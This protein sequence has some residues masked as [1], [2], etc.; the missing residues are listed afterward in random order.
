MNLTAVEIFSA[1]ICLGAPQTLFRPS[2]SETSHSES[3][4]ENVRLNSYE[5]MADFKADYARFRVIDI[6][7]T[8]DSPHMIAA[9]DLNKDSTIDLIHTNW[10]SQS[11]SV[12]ENNEVHGFASRVDYTVGGEASMLASADFD[13]DCDIDIAVASVSTGKIITFQNDGSGVLS[14]WKSYPL[15]Q[16]VGGVC[17]ADLDKDGDMDLAATLWEAGKVFILTNSGLGEFTPSSSHDVGPTPYQVISRDLNSD[18]YEDIIVGNADHYGGGGSIS[19]LSNLTDGNFG[20]AK[21][22]D[23]GSYTLYVASEDLDGDGDYDVTALNR[24]SNTMALFLNDGFGELNLSALIPTGPVPT[25]IELFDLDNDSDKDILVVNSKANSGMPGSLL[26]LWNNGIGSFS[27]EEFVTLGIGP[28]TV[29]VGD[30]D[31]DRDVD[32]GITCWD[33]NAVWILENQLADSNP[34]LLSVSDVPNDQGGKVSLIWSSTYLDTNT[35]TLPYYSIWRSLPPGENPAGPVITPADISID[36]NGPGYRFAEAQSE[37]LA[38]EWIAN[39]PAHRFSEYS[40]TAPTLYDSMSGTDGRHFFLI[41]A[42]TS[43]P[44]IFFDSRPMSGYSVDNLSPSPV[45]QLSALPVLGSGIKLQW[46]PPEDVPDIMEYNIYRSSVPDASPTHADKIGSVV[47][48]AFTDHDP[49]SGEA[50]YYRVTAVDSNG[51]EG[52]PSPAASVSPAVTLNFDYGTGWNLISLPFPVSNPAISALFQNAGSLAYAYDDGYLAFNELSSRKGFW[53]RFNNPDRLTVTGYPVTSDS[54]QLDSGW[55]LI[56]SISESLSAE[57]VLQRSGEFLSSRFFGYTSSG[58]AAA[59]S[60]EPGR[61]YWVK[62]SSPGILFLRSPD[63][64][65]KSSAPDP[66]AMLNQITFVDAKGN[67]QT[68]YY[69]ASTEDLSRWMELPPSPPEGVFDVRFSHDLSLIQFDKSTLTDF[70][71]R[72]AHI[73]YP[74]T[75]SWKTIQQ[76]HLGALQ[77]DGATVPLSGAGMIVVSNPVFEVTLR[78]SSHELH[79]VPTEF[80]LEQNYPNPFNPRTEIRYGLPT[81]SYI[82]VTVHNS[83]GQLVGTL[84]NGVQPDGY[85]SAAWDA[86]AGSL[87][88]GV[89]FARMVATSVDDPTVSFS[90]VVRMLMVK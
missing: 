17:S 38:W 78:K 36:F 14:F 60:L 74:L 49:P 13:S 88:S 85:H 24:D 10:L 35:T 83:I 67:S 1:M 63:Q 37:T 48:T 86:S 68:M 21:E 55:N 4:A 59:T 26:L 40:Y 20:D 22:Y 25:W 82:S 84:V 28:R 11:I 3:S 70:A 51:N 77:L 89:Y 7:P 41:S 72:L 54:L 76:D 30:F 42:H 27:L 79:R 64:F 16:I 44:N 65:M 39:Q 66:L 19:V 71:I 9:V 29:A 56:G 57:D 80:S 87:P 18:G 61:A 81:A 52:L 50:L 58:Y 32:L 34:S 2:G 73:E 6:R 69:G 62:A 12:H 47:V 23:A 75:I 15:G 46:S 8:P 53:L 90:R 45:I 5:A 43:D 31:G 33:D